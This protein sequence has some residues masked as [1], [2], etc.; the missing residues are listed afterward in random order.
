MIMTTSLQGA[1][2]SLQTST[3]L[4]SSSLSILE[5][6]VS[7]FP[8]LSKVLSQTRHF[9]LLPSSSL[10]S[11]QDALLAELTPEVESLLTRV[12]TYVERLERR[13]S[14]L[15]ARWELQEGRLGRETE[16]GSR[17]VIGNGTRRGPNGI[18][19]DDAGGRKL[20][21]TG[22][23]EELKAKQLRQK[24]DRL[25]YAVERLTMQAQQ[26]ERKLRQSMAAQERKVHQDDDDELA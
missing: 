10:S 13:E 3:A 21:N 8:R 26:T 11:A 12:E 24:R 22:A 15:R 5:A 7:D 2:S 25:S 23:R 19:R 16:G 6:G 14:S 9:E 17:D 4:L 20:D 18:G 1:L